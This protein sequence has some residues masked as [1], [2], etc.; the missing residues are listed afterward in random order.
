MIL[1]SLVAWFALAALVLVAFVIG[2]GALLTNDRVAAYAAQRC[3]RV[4]IYAIVLA[5]VGGLVLGLWL[6]L[7]GPMLGRALWEVDAC[8]R[9]LILL[10]PLLIIVLVVL[11]LFVA[12]CH[13]LVW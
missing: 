4:C 8:L 9:W 11:V 1:C 7:G 5:F 3:G 2:G 12:A 13:T 6:C 10:L